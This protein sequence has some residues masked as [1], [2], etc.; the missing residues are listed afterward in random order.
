MSSGLFSNRSYRSA[1]GAG[2]LRYFRVTVGETDLSI[3]AK[4]VLEDEARRAALAAR[5]EIYAQIDAR[6]RFKSSLE[7]LSIHGSET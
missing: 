1:H 6:P 5:D 3:G 2:D 4:A 7:P